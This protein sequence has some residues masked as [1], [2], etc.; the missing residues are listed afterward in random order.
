[1]HKKIKKVREKQRET[2]LIIDNIMKRY[3]ERNI[4]NA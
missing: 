1:M 3:L 4:H 2:V